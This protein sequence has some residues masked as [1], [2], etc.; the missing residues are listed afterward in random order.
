MLQY[1]YFVKCPGCEDEHF[2]FFNEAKEF[3]M[4]CL[5]QKPIITQIEID[6]NDFGECT[7][8]C[9]LGTVWSW[10]DMMKDVPT[11]SE[12][13]FTKADTLECGHCCDSE[14]D[15]LDNSLEAIPDNFR[16]PIPEGMTIEQLVEEMEENEDDVECTWCEDI[17]DK[18]ECRYEVNLGWLCDRCQAAI[19][20]RG[21]PLTFRENSYWDFLDESK[22]T[23]E[24]L[25]EA[26]DPRKQVGLEYKD[27]TVTITTRVIPAT[28]LDP[29]EYEE[30]DITQDFIYN[31]DA[32]DVATTIW[33]NFITD[34]DVADVPGGLDTL[35]NDEPWQAFLAAH[36]D[37]LVSKYYTQ[38]LD[39]Y[40][41][42]AEEA[43]VEEFQ[44]DYARLH[45]GGPDPDSAYDEWRDSQ[46][47]GEGCEQRKSFLEEFDDAET[48]KANMADCPECGA[49]SYDM[50]EQ[51]CTNCGLN[52]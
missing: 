15:A 35:E 8:S 41:A 3:A 36:F 52:L 42:D 4:N 24:L 11:E 6:R 10:E 31:V 44:D 47:F 29:E 26:F 43:A 49:V 7:N 33:E 19:M 18:S 50:K 39:F 23:E 40:R 51:Y 12:I 37:D 5:S 13:A 30:E 28:R 38:L 45:S 25:D 46:Y 1:I 34:D 21:E 20:S 2:D 17:F 48:H 14:F 22:D 27:L 9:D 16:K 32:E